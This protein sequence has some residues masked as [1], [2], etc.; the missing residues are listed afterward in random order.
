MNNTEKIQRLEEVW[1]EKALSRENYDF[2]ATHLPFNNL[3]YTVKQGQ[4]SKDSLTE[5][6]FLEDYILKDLNSHRLI[7]V[8]GDSGSGKSHLIRWFYNGYKQR[9]PNDDVVVL[10]S[11]EENSLKGTLNQILNSPMVEG[12]E[13]S[14]KIKKLDDASQALSQEDII[15][16]ILALLVAEANKDKSKETIINKRDFANLHSFLTDEVIRE[17]LLLK[18]DGPIER[19]AAKVSTGYGIKNYELDPKFYMEDLMVSKDIL[20]KMESPSNTSARRAI[21]FAKRIYSGEE[22]SASIL[23]EYL[24]SK[25]NSVIRN[26]I[27]LNQED[28]RDVFKEIRENLKKQNKNLILFIED[29]TTMM[30]I[31]REL[32]ESLTIDHKSSK[33][34]CRLVSFVGITNSYYNSDVPS[35]IHERVTDSLEITNDSLIQTDD[36]LYKMIGKYINCIQLEKEEV[37]N[38]YKDGVDYEKLPIAEFNKSKKYSLVDIGNGKEVSIYPFTK[39]YITNIYKGLNKLDRKPREIIRIFINQLYYSYLL[40][41]EIGLLKTDRYNGISIPNWEE[42]V[43]RDN[44]ERNNQKNSEEISLIVR[45]W[46]DSNIILYEQDGIRYYGG[47]GHY[48]FDDFNIKEPEGFIYKNL[49]GVEDLNRPKVEVKNTIDDKEEKR[50]EKGK[51][52]NSGMLNREAQRFNDLKN[53]LDRWRKGNNLISHKELRS[54]IVG[55]FKEFIYWEKEGI[56]P[57]YIEDMLTM[58]LIHIE[59]Q[60]VN[61]GNGL[62][63]PRNDETYYY[64]I[65]LISW[66]YK[67]SKSWNFD[68][69]IEYIYRTTSLLEK[70]KSKVIKLIS[71][72]VD[73][74][75]EDWC[76]EDWLVLNNFYTALV[77]GEIDIND[78]I[79]EI[80]MKILSLSNKDYTNKFINSNRKW[81]PYARNI[82]D[83]DLIRENILTLK[84]FYNL[85]LGEAHTSRTLTLNAYRLLTKIEDLDKGNWK[86]EKYNLNYDIRDSKL[87]SPVKAFKN[88]FVDKLPKILKYESDII[89]LEK[90]KLKKYL[91]LDRYSKEEFKIKLEKVRDHFKIYLASISSLNLFYKSEDYKILLSE[92]SKIIDAYIG[93]IDY[94]FNFENYSML[95]KYIIL[96]KNHLDKLIELNIELSNVDNLIDRGEKLINTN[97]NVDSNEEIELYNKERELEKHITLIQ[98][99]TKRLLGVL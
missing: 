13:E 99:K 77:L 79:D 83:N 93:S 75:E 30:G 33:N 37:K 86:L 69:S 47:V 50:E 85:K 67:G 72:P 92:N 53:D 8:K 63:L 36:D 60:N 46:G 82:A 74:P 22:K 91:S 61:I 3:K 39:K 34:L 20:K 21:R 5:N 14:E 49:E 28:L 44:I 25:I 55:N 97:W 42:E 17:E 45:L 76:Y 66:T 70:Y 78:S 41:G 52:E 9:N 27:K 73:W 96:S 35:N 38:W 71:K 6:E 32:L 43:F 10:I 24:N 16:N 2:M 19:I 94:I 58:S 98:D 31:D 15:E 23:A 12:L 80:Y 87:F 59:G 18:E 89:E 1:N 95:E 88:Q 57:L 29:I 81:G 56:S 4:H 11:R 62:V 84:R 51:I 48:I 65:G 26:M 54:M 64:L 90:A 7:M 40:E 68:N